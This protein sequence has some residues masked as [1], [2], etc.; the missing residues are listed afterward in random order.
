MTE[1]LKKR[2]VSPVTMRSVVRGAIAAASLT[3]AAA[4]A[5][6]LQLAPVDDAWV[7]G[8]PAYVDQNFGADTQLVVW[9]NFP[10]WG[11]RSY[12]KF[13]LSSI[14]SGH[15]VTG[16]TLELYVFNG[17][18][19]GSGIDIWR[20]GSDA[21]S[22]STI[23][24]N[25][26]PTPLNPNPADLIAQNLSVFGSTRGW[27]SFDL[28]ASGVWDPEQDRAGGDGLLSVIARITGGEFNTQ[29]AY[30]ICSSEAGGFDCLQTGETGPF[31]DRGPRLVLTT[32]PVPETNASLLMLI[33]CAGLAASRRRAR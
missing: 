28:L 6:T 9:A 4:H 7:V 24:W 8:D 23:T 15:V 30:N 20:V 3:A 5:T 25:S 29:R 1:D 13:D 17:G 21:W 11:G 2:A 27:I 10:N 31:F 22:E 18:G 16:A 12:L 26:Q 19:L 33:A 14:P 32:A